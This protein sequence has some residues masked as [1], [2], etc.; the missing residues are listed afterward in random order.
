MP[1]LLLSGVKLSLGF[2][3]KRKGEF[4]TARG[5]SFKREGFQL[6]TLVHIRV[7]KQLKK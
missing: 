3:F 7:C 5:N 6:N 1:L 2:I 4:C